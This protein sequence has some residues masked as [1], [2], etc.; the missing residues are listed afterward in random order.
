M[1]QPRSVIGGHLL[2]AAVGYL[3]L[4]GC[5][6]STWAAVLAGGIAAGAMMVTRTPYSPA[7]ATAFIVVPQSRAPLRLL[8]LL[9]SATVVLVAAGVVAGRPARATRYPAY[10]W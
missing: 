4:A 6:S 3:V 5:G 2:S 1:A 8:A 9:T 7:A 10:W